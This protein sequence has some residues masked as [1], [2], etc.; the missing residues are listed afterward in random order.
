MMSSEKSVVTSMVSTVMA[1]MMAAMMTSVM[2][3]VSMVPVMM[4][5]LMDH[6]LDESFVMS[7]VMAMVRWE[8]M[9]SVMATMV[10][11][12]DWCWLYVNDLSGW[13]DMVRWRYCM[14][15][16]MIA[17]LHHWLRLIYDRSWSKSWLW[18]HVCSRVHS[19][20]RHRSSLRERLLRM[21]RN[22]ARWMLLRRI[23][24]RWLILIWIHNF[25][26]N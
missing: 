23:A 10:L 14:H 3:V 26:I 21:G 2:P 25:N 17:R 15:A 13:R 7:A 19:R 1:A 16:W 20:V 8:V 24:R 22:H 6:M 5:G 18:R 11:N 9:P 12:D 4:D